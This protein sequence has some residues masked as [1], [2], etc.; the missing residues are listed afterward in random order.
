MQHH[1]NV[2]EVEFRLENFADLDGG[3]PAEMVARQ[4]ARIVDDVR[5]RPGDKSKR[6]LIIC[7]EIVPK[8]HAE[9]DDF[10]ANVTVL[11]GLAVK[12]KAKVS[13]P[14]QSTAEYDI[15]VK[16]DG[17][18]IFNPDH[19]FNHRQASLPF[20]RGVVDGMVTSVAVDQ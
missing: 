14:D 11:D 18:I 10:G 5:R 16:G 20:E 4:L 17:R 15:G 2:K 6:K 1:P 13:M 7:A 8:V 9:K 19:P 3:I 12:I